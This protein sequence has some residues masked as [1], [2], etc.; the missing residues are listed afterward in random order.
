[1]TSSQSSVH[2]G[3]P[4][5]PILLITK[6]PRPVVTGTEMV[7]PRLE[8]SSVV[9]GAAALVPVLLRQC[10]PQRSARAARWRE[11]LKKWKNKKR[12]ISS[13]RKKLARFCRW[14]Q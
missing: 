4:R 3:V 11:R 10:V 6:L 1:M 9:R 5:S 2:Q 8:A 12:G 14:C 13:A 7:H